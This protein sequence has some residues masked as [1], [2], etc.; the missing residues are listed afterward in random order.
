MKI[1]RFFSEDARAT[2]NRF[3]RFESRDLSGEAVFYTQF[4]LTLVLPL[5][6]IGWFIDKMRRMVFADKITRK[7][8]KKNDSGYNQTRKVVDS[9]LKLSARGLNLEEKK[10]ALKVASSLGYNQFFA[11]LFQKLT[12]EKDRE[13]II[14]EAVKMALENKQPRSIR[15]IKQELDWRGTEDLQKVFE[16]TL[17]DELPKHIG[18]KEII[19]AFMD[20]STKKSNNLWEFDPPS[21]SPKFRAKP[22]LIAMEAY[23]RKVVETLILEVPHQEDEINSAFPKMLK[24]HKVRTH[25][26][27]LIVRA[28]KALLTPENRA[29]AISYLSRPFQCEYEY[30]VK[31]LLSDPQT[32][33]LVLSRKLDASTYAVV[34][35]YIPENKRLDLKVWRDFNKVLN[36]QGEEKRLVTI[37]FRHALVTE[38]QEE[39][40]AILEKFSFSTLLS[41][42]GQEALDQALLIATGGNNANVVDR[43]VKGGSFGTIQ[44]ALDIAASAYD[45]TNNTLLKKLYT[46]AGV[47]LDKALLVAV[48]AN[49]AQAVEYLMSKSE[50]QSVCFPKVIEWAV[51]H[52]TPSVHTTFEKLYGQ[53]KDSNYKDTLI[54]EACKKADAINYIIEK[55]DISDDQ[56]KLI[57]SAFARRENDKSIKLYKKVLTK[58]KN[59]LQPSIYREALET[60]SGPMLD[61]LLQEVT[62]NA[63]V[64]VA[65]IKRYLQENSLD[66]LK[67]LLTSEKTQ[68]VQKT[69]TQ[70][71]VEELIRNFSKYNPVY[72]H[73]LRM[74]PCLK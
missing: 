35:K 27:S 50:N 71:S 49:N 9:V 16:K 55:H 24:C 13:E 58:F 20:G 11:G 23:D 36:S 29:L 72:Q 26:V 54:L 48:E 21:L 45:A 64:V 28:H 62:L 1:H 73:Y 10:L 39:L 19:S 31:D 25:E 67:Q 56:I 70:E 51:K 63:E 65:A 18:D 69:I 66:R 34:K 53:L 6:G 3:L 32:L 22:L 17:D 33:N 46:C 12:N 37:T 68:E 47:S 38:D 59:R 7:L 74:I 52:Y 40:K 5:I 15:V 4:L 57:L 61:L 8:V 44:E 30:L 2:V 42:C 14:P 43:L 41:H 60:S